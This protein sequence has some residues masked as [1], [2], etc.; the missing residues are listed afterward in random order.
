MK[1][2]FE[3]YDTLPENVQE[4]VSILI[5]GSLDGSRQMIDQA[6]DELALL[7]YE[8]EMGL[9]LVPYNLKKTKDVLH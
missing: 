4:W 8:F 2:L 5:Q 1:D 7:G 6:E 3:Q 9:D